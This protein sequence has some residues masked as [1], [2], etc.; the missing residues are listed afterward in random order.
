MH[1]RSS[2][3][4]WAMLV[5]VLAACAPRS[6]WMSFAEYAERSHP[7]PYVLR[8]QLGD[9]TLLYFGSAHVYDPDDAQVAD[10]A[11]LWSQL[12]PTI[13][14]NE[15]GDPPALPDV[16]AAVAQH[17]EAGL[18]RHLAARDGVPIRSLEPPYA[19]QVAALR[20]DFSVEQITVFYVARQLEQHHRRVTTE[21]P[22]ALVAR[23]LAGLAAVP[24]L[25]DAPRTPAALA[26]ACA[27]LLPPP[28]D[29]SHPEAAWFDPA[30][31]DTGA[32]TN[33][34]TRQL[35]QQ[36]DEWMVELL[37]AAVQPGAR[38][39]A[40][41]GSSHVYMQQRALEQALGRRAD[42]R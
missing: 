30:R 13:A 17:G 26:D 39:F 5:A 20:R 15:G 7:T 42:R 4:L 12:R 36:R 38:V 29:C 32:Y 1:R 6:P 9:A 33:E 40:V 11:G 8:W 24:G 18:L 23:S 34:L 31:F 21:S 41:V 16:A 3:V 37:R 35:S 10:I 28:G 25:E 19:A 2:P 22:E 14:F 27:R